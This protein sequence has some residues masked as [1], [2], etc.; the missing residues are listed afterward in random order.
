ME[1]TE[2]QSGLENY[3]SE[4]SDLE[5]KSDK[6]STERTLYDYFQDFEW[7]F[8]EIHRTNGPPISIPKNSKC[9]TAIIEEVS[10]DVAEKMAE[11]HGAVLIESNS[12][13]Y[14]DVNLRNIFDA[15]LIALDFKSTRILDSGE[16]VS[17]MTLGSCGEYFSNPEENTQY[18]KFAYGSYDEH[19]VVCFAYKWNP[20]RSSENMV[21]DIETL[22]GKK[23][24]FAKN[25]TST[26]STNQITSQTDLR[27]LRNRVPHFDSKKDFERQW[28]EHGND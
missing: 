3:S 15:N 9:V 13:Q 7:N 21:Y 24:E 2:W 18:S 8:S 22:V 6:G 12:R 11:D 17:G 23:W 5:V 20:S 10:M 26:N 28:R 25:P 14:P 4:D 27:A 16:K 19:W 1:M